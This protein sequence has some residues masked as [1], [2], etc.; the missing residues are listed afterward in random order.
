MKKVLIVV[1]SLEEKNSVFQH[2][3]TIVSELSRL[4]ELSVIALLDSG[5]SYFHP[6]G[7]RVF[8]AAMDSQYRIIKYL[9]FLKLFMNVLNTQK[10]EAVISHMTDSVAAIYSPILWAM[11]R[12]HVLWYAHAS[13]SI[14]LRIA[15]FFV[16]QIV[17]STP[18]SIPIKGRKISPIGQSIDIDFFRRDQSHPI[19]EKHLR[20]I[21]VGR[22]DESKRIDELCEI[23]KASI[24][25]NRYKHFALVGSPSKNNTR[26]ADKLFTKYS[27]EIN[28]G[29]IE[30]LGSLDRIQVKKQLAESHLFLHAFEGS[31]DKTL[32][33]ATAMKLPVVTCNYE[34][35]LE[36]GSWSG[37][38]PGADFRAYLNT[39]ISA[40]NSYSTKQIAA[41]VEQRH[42]LIVTK[43]SLGNW[44]SQ[45]EKI[46]CEESF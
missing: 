33:E 2:Q 3:M 4:Y 32:L 38:T 5:R 17:T 1:Y 39:E 26:Y 16:T 8:P 29:T 42:N 23:F 28:V 31:L 9:R 21:H 19:D 15:K 27:H 11:K 12:F 7:F 44:I 34:Y 20:V 14:Y 35:V 24:A 36:F 43:H 6:G 40:F 37:S 45:I 13:Y 41:I 25:S 30:F 18:G 10:P 46:I 22:L